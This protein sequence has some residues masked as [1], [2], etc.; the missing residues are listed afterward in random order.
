MSTDPRS[1]RTL[2][3]RHGMQAWY[4]RLCWAVP[5][6]N[7]TPGAVGTPPRADEAEGAPLVDEAVGGGRDDRGVDDG[8]GARAGFEGPV[9]LRR[10]ARLCWDE[11]LA[12]SFTA[13]AAAAARAY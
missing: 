11:P 2:R 10:G 8:P 6:A 5:G 3:R 7:A 13:D 9:G 12:S 4:T 1:H